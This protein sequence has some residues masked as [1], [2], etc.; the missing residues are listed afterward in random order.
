M[1]NELVIF[2]DDEIK[3]EVPISAKDET[4][5]LNRDQMAKLFDRDIKT[6]GKHIKN[7]INEE[8]SGTS[9]V[10]KFATVQLEGTRQVERLIE[11]YN[12]DVIISVGYRVK[13]K[14]GVAFRKW[15]N[16]VLKE[17][18]IKGYAINQQRLNQLNQVLRIMK[19]SETALDAK[20]VLTVV[21]RYNKALDLLDDY[22][23][24]KLEKPK[25][26]KTT[27]ILTYEECRKVID[28][29]KFSSDSKLFGNEKDDSFKGSI[30]NIYQSFAGVDIYPSLEEK[31][32]NLLYFVTKNHSFSDGNKRIAATMFLYFLDRNDVLF[33]NHEKLIDDHTLVALVIMIA[34]SRPEEKDV[35]ISIIM[36]CIS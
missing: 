24:Q 2:E 19:R 5:W 18:I 15:A 34:E 12:L 4:V 23:H 26:N 30:G 3:L 21:E 8:L 22:D 7:A 13:S 1:D 9:T 29:M 28:E 17:Y 6:I 33:T 25:G 14:R 35:M 32:A 20:Q 36:N 16:S 31:A 27:Y 11:Y 10:A